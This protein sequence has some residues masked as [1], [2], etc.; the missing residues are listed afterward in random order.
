MP[1]QRIKQYEGALGKFEYNSSDFEL[2]YLFNFTG[3]KEY[4]KYRGREINGKNIHIPEGIKDISYMFQHCSLT[5]PPTIPFSVIIMNYT[6]K[7]CHSLKIG[8]VMP[9]GVTKANGLY[10]NCRELRSCPP[11]VPTLTHCAFMFDGCV[12]LQAPPVLSPNLEDMTCMFRNCRLMGQVPVIPES[13][14]KTDGIFRGCDTLNL[15]CSDAGNA[16]DSEFLIFSPAATDAEV[17]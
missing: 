17:L 11:L 13:A 8:A 7:D 16:D 10:Q 12:R 4:L 6:F 3:R 14:M 9:Y 2:A 5:T 15:A 1:L